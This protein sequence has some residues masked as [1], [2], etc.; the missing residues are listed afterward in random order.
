RPSLRAAAS[1]SDDSFSLAPS[2]LAS[3]RAISELLADAALPDGSLAFASAEK[4]RSW[5]LPRLEKD[6]I[7][8]SAVTLLLPPPIPAS[9]FPALASEGRRRPLTTTALDAALS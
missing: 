7:V 2:R 4:L 6:D 3:T 5:R 1:T 9:F 8:M